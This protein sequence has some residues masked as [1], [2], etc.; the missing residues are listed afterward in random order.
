MMG[1]MLELPHPHKPGR[2]FRVYD[3]FDAAALD[4]CATDS[5]GAARLPKIRAALDTLRAGSE[6]GMA[7]RVWQ[8]RT[9]AGVYVDPSG[10]LTHVL[11]H[12]HDTLV[13]R[14]PSFQARRGM[15]SALSSI[16]VQLKRVP[17]MMLPFLDAH[18]PD[19]Q[20][21]Q[22]P[23]HPHHITHSSH[24]SSHPSLITS[25]T[26]HIHHSRAAVGRGLGRGD[27]RARLCAAHEHRRPPP[28]RHQ[29]P[30]N[31][32]RRRRH[33]MTRSLHE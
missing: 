29:A 26:H 4:T 21:T 33:C 9:P 13:R 14:R 32:R 2:V 19:Q 30:G 7:V 20:T 28:H 11:Q 15:Q 22:A 3:E 17:T 27:R 16:S 10:D 23:A 18:V 31:A 12:I 5:A 25:V 6:D 8:Q 1:Q 24:H